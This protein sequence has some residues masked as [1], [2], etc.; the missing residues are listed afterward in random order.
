[1][2]LHMLKDCRSANNP[3]FWMSLR[4]L[5]YKRYLDW[6]RSRNVRIYRWAL[7]A[8][9]LLLGGYLESVL[10]GES[11]PPKTTLVYSVGNVFQR[12][13]AFC[14]ALPESALEVRWQRLTCCC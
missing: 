8:V 7:P 2:T 6:T 9:I 11:I 1:M 4:C 3:G 13:I 5:V 14:D 10:I 12:P